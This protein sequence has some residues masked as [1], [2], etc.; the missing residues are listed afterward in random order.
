[1]TYKPI[2]TLTEITQ[3]LDSLRELLDD[4]AAKQREI[5][6]RVEFI[7]DAVEALSKKDKKQ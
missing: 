4:V 1:M 5:A 7:E 3:D 6:E 2:K